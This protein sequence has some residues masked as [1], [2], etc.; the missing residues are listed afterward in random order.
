ME[1]KELY[2]FVF[3]LIS[4]AMVLAVGIL[5]LDNFGDAVKESASLT[6]ESVIFAAGVGSTA[7]DEV[8]DVTR[9]GNGTLSCVTFNTASWCANWTPA[10]DLALNVSTFGVG[11]LAG[12]YHVTYTYDADTDATTATTAVNTALNTISSTWL[13]LIIT[14]AILAIVLVLVIRSFGRTR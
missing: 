13:T 5:T 14:V 11:G 6:N 10:G 7:N 8:T 2:P 12:T 9:I 1:I 4:I 3:I